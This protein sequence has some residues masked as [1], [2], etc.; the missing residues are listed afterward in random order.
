LN[1]GRWKSLLAA[2]AVAL[3]GCASIAVPIGGLVPTWK[4]P[5]SD[6]D[7][8]SGDRLRGR[9]GLVVWL[10]P[11]CPE[12]QQAATPGG[13]LRRMES[14]WMPT[15]SAWIVYV[16]ARTRPDEVMD[17]EMWRPWMKEMKLRGPVL[18]DSAA[19]LSRAL[20]AGFAPAAAVVDQDGV[21]RWRGPLRAQDS[22]GLPL[23]SRVLD[24]VLAGRALPTPD[25]RMDE[26]CP[27]RDRVW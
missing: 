10:D 4:L 17:P 6:G 14:R 26:G 9:P 5:T 13:A 23:A 20:G 22:S 24:S 21:L 7:T 27:M 1:P 2:W 25:D 16:A 19:T 11:M 3:S 15:D 8:L 12:V 18:V